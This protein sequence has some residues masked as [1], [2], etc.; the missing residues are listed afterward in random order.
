MGWGGGVGSYPLLS[1]APTHVEVE[2]G[3]DNINIPPT[4]RTS[5]QPINNWLQNQQN[6]P[7]VTNPIDNN[8]N[9]PVNE[10]IN[11]QK[12]PVTTSI[13]NPQDTL[14][15]IVPEDLQDTFVDMIRKDPQELSVGD[16]QKDHP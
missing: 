3:C 2:L 15:D 13:S 6:T 9:D 14:A 16:A 4:D 7:V 11:P 10:E 12:E 1:Q 8:E 5:T